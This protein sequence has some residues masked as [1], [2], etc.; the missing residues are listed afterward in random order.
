MN[1]LVFSLLLVLIF[2]ILVG[3]STERFVVHHVQY[4]NVHPEESALGAIQ[5]LEI[6]TVGRE[7]D[8]LRRAYHFEGLAAAWP[9]VVRD[10]ARVLG[11]T[12]QQQQTPAQ[13][14]QSQMQ[15]A[16][17]LSSLD[18]SGYLDKMKK[19][20]PAQTQSGPLWLQ[21]ATLARTL[22]SAYRQS[23]A[24][25]GQEDYATVGIL[26]KPMSPMSSGTEEEETSK[27]RNKL[28]NK[29]IASSL[30]SEGAPW[31]PRASPSSS[32]SSNSNSM[33]SN[34]NM[35]SYTFLHCIHAP[36]K[37]HALCA[38]GIAQLDPTTSSAGSQGFRVTT[39]AA[40]GAIPEDQLWTFARDSADR[41]A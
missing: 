14:P 30:F 6:V 10:A 17:Q 2:I 38:S 5:P 9:E 40:S 33:Y 26:L 3:L 36:G 15:S 4:G 32:L 24:M 7:S 31:S 16:S 35:N 1:L 39:I 22:L 18:T 13:T 8:Q 11:A 34:L 19:E 25:R 21:S 37:A 23:S 29:P 28:R 20:D 12:G 41:P 27:L